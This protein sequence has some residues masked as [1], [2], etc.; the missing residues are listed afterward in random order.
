MPPNIYC[1]HHPDG[2]THCWHQPSR[3]VN[4]IQQ[5][6]CPLLI[7]CFC[8]TV[9]AEVVN[10]GDGHGFHVTKSQDYYVTNPEKSKNT[11]L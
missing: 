7:C 8:G 5:D 6:I 9:I 1:P 10:V 4:R 3:Q 2:G 11:T